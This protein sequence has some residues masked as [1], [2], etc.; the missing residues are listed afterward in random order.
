MFVPLL[1]SLTRKSHADSVTADKLSYN[2]RV[3]ALESL[4]LRFE[5]KSRMKR[6]PSTVQ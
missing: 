3:L 6:L 4:S 1:G 2:G 5:Q